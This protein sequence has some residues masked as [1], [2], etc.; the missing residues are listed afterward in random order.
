VKLQAWTSSN[1]QNRWKPTLSLIL[2]IYYMFS[3][4]VVKWNKKNY[5]M[6]EWLKL[7]G[8]GL[9]LGPLTLHSPPFGHQNTF[10]YG[11]KL[12]PQTFWAKVEW[13]VHTWKSS[14]RLP[15]KILCI[16]IQCL[17]PYQ[18]GQIDRNLMKPWG[19][20]PNTPIHP[21]FFKSLWNFEQVA[22]L[23]I[24]FVHIR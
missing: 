18:F 15:G 17:F 14:S 11:I 7:E 16:P 1:A 21:F 20:W 3:S 5:L 8:R 19:I 9:F 23:K 22:S 13:K 24:N 12:G 2:F 10:Q 6:K 4:L